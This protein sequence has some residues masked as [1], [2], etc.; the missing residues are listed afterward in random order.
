MA[1]SAK[2][3]SHPVSDTIE[4]YQRRVANR[5]SADAERPR[6]SRAGI[7]TLTS[8]AAAVSVAGSADAVILYSGV[9]D[10]ET[11]LVQYPTYS[12]VYV[13]ARIAVDLDLDGDVDG[14]FVAARGY[15]VGFA[16]LFRDQQTGVGVIADD[17]V[18]PRPNRPPVYPYYANDYFNIPNAVAFETGEV[19]SSDAGRVVRD[20]LMHPSGSALQF[21]QRRFLGTA[22]IAGFKVDGRFG[23]I[24]LVFAEITPEERFECFQGTQAPDVDCTPRGNLRI[25]DYAIE[26]EVGT[27]IIAGAVP[28]PGTG[29]LV[30]LGLLAL[31]ARGVRERRR[32]R[33]LREAA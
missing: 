4:D 6:G 26:T 13:S 19:I 2:H 22:A 33:K 9:V 3:A 23:W 14:D 12:D 32:Q 5:R 8:A 28:E 15:E 7:A 24:R 20:A 10:L 1:R 16:G 21:T 11:Q 31:G 29:T 17:I 25:I 30:G 27:P 18:R